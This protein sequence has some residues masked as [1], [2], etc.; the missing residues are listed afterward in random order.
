MS[1]WRA[2][3]RLR[4]SRAVREGLLAGSR[5]WLTGRPLYWSS[6]ICCGRRAISGWGVCS[7]GLE[8]ATNLRC[9]GAEGSR[10]LADDKGQAGPQVDGVTIN[11]GNINEGAAIDAFDLEL[12]KVLENIADLSTVATATRSITLKVDFKPESDRC[13]VHTEFSISAKLAGI[14]K[15][16]SKIFVA[17]T[18]EGA[19]VALDADPRQMP[20]WTTPAKAQPPVIQFANNK[21]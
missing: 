20:L 1:R 14:E 11:I 16:V 12:R 17:K 19:L 6:G 5:G 10:I 8:E 21:Q 2:R 7:F 9:D 13:K 4:D 18:D 15:H 3:K